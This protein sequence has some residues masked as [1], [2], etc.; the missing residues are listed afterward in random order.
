M[1][2]IED[3]NSPATVGETEANPVIVKGKRGPK[4][5]VLNFPIDGKAHTLCQLKK[6]L[7]VS[8]PTLLKA[9]DRTE[10][11]ILTKKKLKTK[12]RAKYYYTFTN[13]VPKVTELQPVAA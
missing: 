9:I 7:K 13:E 8:M 3:N 6:R 12:G 5:K 4:V 1:N 10:N 11:K 2:N